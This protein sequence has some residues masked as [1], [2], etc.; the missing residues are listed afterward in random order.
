M[1]NRKARYRSITASVNLFLV[2]SL[3]AGVGIVIAAFSV[4]LLTSRDRLTRDNLM[5]QGNLLF[6]SIENFMLPGDA[7]Y[8]VKFVKQVSGDGTATNISLY[9]RD[10]RPAFSDNATI[11]RVNANL[12]Q[13]KFALRP[14]SSALPAAAALPPKPRFAEATS[15][16]PQEV[17]FREGAGG[18][19][20]FR[21]YWPL[22]NLPKC[23]VCHGSDHTVRGVLDIRS[24][25]TA[26][27][28]SQNILLG[29][30]ILGFFLVVGFLAYV[31]GGFLR[32]LVLSPIKAIGRLCTD[33]TSGS[34]EGRVEAGARNE[35]GDLARTVNQ[36]VGGLKERFELTKYVSRGTIGAL[37]EGQ[38]PR[39]HQRTLLFTDVRGFTSYTESHDP[40]RVVEALNRLLERQSEI[41]HERGGDIDKFVGDEVVAVFS[42][43]DATRRALLAGRD[44]ARL[45]R[46]RPADF[47]GLDVG[48]GVAS[49]PV[50]QGMIGSE[51]RADFTVVGDSVN[52]ASRLC[53]IAK[54]GQVIV[55]DKA[56]GEAGED[57]AF[58][59]PFGAKLK[60]KAE[61]QKVWLLRTGGEPGGGEA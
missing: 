51:R 61:A 56:R 10:G 27:V 12:K 43:E 22:I 16:P 59:G 3:A 13:A 46:M 39:R 5:Q 4:S 17:F 54:K 32:R 57:F 9:R 28:R 42:G 19:T 44:I 48:V 55:S 23:S 34:F 8:A 38:R 47:D 41:I 1:A 29:A 15:I 31:I 20:Y 53:S 26:V 50:I 14:V 11:E 30:G 36:M 35:I 52:V 2:L 37:A 18:H 33:V 6:A 60:G 40:E 24:D 21:A 7:P 58:D 25:V 49:G 45:C